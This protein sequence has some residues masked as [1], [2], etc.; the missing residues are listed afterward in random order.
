M[1]RF[2]T[3]MLAP[4]L[5]FCAAADQETGSA[6]AAE[7]AAPAAEN[8][9]PAAE[10]PVP[11]AEGKTYE[12]SRPFAP[13]DADARFARVP[14]EIREHVKRMD[15]F[16]SSRDSSLA[17]VRE[18]ER[19]AEERR[20]AIREENPEAKALYDRIAEI[21]AELEAATNSLAAIYG[22]DEELAAILAGVGEAAESAENNQR[23]LNEEIARAV[24]A[25]QS[26]QYRAQSGE[27]TGAFDAA[28]R[29]EPP[30]EG[31]K[32]APRRPGVPEASDFESGRYRRPAGDRNARYGVPSGAGRPDIKPPLERPRRPGEKPEEN[33]APQPPQRPASPGAPAVAETPDEASAGPDVD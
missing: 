25:R 17:K 32:R 1:K 15:S 6:A 3:F 27:G 23:E 5:A 10:A 2:T 28:V 29:P 13:G 22:A 9:S 7:G 24:R 4:L 21:T 11:A 16:R 26:V 12:R 14:P 18:L 31:E 33:L 19:K 30:K 8:V 20:S